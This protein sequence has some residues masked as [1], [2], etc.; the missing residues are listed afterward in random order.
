MTQNLF[1]CIV[2][3]F[4]SKKINV[5]CRLYKLIRTFRIVKKVLQQQIK[6]EKKVITLYSYSKLTNGM[7]Y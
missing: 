2:V 4:P 5:E 6:F 1:Y 3:R 7:V